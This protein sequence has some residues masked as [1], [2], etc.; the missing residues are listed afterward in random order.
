MT[1]P[2]LA[3][4]ARAAGNLSDAIR[5]GRSVE[6]PGLADVAAVAGEALANLRVTAGPV[7]RKAVRE[8]IAAHGVRTADELLDALAATRPDPG[9]GT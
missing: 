7:I 4:A 9:S 3:P 8:R 1:N 6:H 5:F 2:S